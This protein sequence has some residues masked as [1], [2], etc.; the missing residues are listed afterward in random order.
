[1]AT[2]T[3]KE[4]W[5]IIAAFNWDE[6]NDD[7]NNDKAVMEP[8]IA[9]L[10]Q[11]SVE[12]IYEFCELMARFL[13]QLDTREHARY[14][15][16]GE[17]DPDNGND[18]ISAD[19]FLYLRCVV[20][21]N[22]SEYYHKVVADPTQMPRD[23]EFES[24]LYLPALAYK[25]K[26]GEELDHS[27]QINFESFSNKSGWAPTKNTTPGIFTDESTPPGNRRPS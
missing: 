18:Y 2:L 20:L 8:A 24:L 5:K 13:Y 15:Y 3:E 6:S 19:D 4:F 26:T 17:A 14:G 22:G 23:L 21:V 16:L 12:D 27:T 25:R 9:L 1:M 11:R 7:L 10:A